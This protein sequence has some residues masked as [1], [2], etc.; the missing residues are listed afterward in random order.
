MSL[1]IMV[2]G[3]ASTPPVEAPSDTLS[4]AAWVEVDG[5]PPF[6]LRV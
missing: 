1:L 5:F 6:P 2:S 3:S 4:W